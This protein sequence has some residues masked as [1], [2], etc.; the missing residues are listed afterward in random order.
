MI[1][2]RINYLDKSFLASV[3]SGSAS[4]TLKITIFQIKISNGQNITR[5]VAEVFVVKFLNKLKVDIFQNLSK[6]TFS[7]LIKTCV[8][9][10]R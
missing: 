7:N 9:M 10:L 1:S 2:V 8:R 4:M 6:L 3:E 5:R